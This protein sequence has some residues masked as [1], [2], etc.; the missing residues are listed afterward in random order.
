MAASTVWSPMSN[1]NFKK[2]PYVVPYNGYQNVPRKYRNDVLT[3]CRNWLRELLFI[4]GNH[5]WLSIDDDIRTFQVVFR[6]CQSYDWSTEKGSKRHDEMASI[7]YYFFFFLHASY[8]QT[9]YK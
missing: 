4:T 3:L 8:S 5:R 6:I 1:C 2:L 7:F 9:Y